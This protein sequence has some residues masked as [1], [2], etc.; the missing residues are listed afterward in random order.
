MARVQAYKELQEQANANDK[1][2][3]EE[4]AKV[5]TDYHKED[6][7]VMQKNEGGWHFQFKEE[8]NDI[9]LDV[10]TGKYLD[11]SLI[12]VDVHPK[13]IIITI[14]GKVL[15]L[16]LPDEVTPD[17]TKALRS[18]TTGTNHEIRT[19]HKK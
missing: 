10:A 15:R 12:D 13:Y 1:K 16:N 4:E 14:K 6:G 2:P 19:T 7:T 9:I 8:P 3:V 5:E 18:Q 11:T 17:S